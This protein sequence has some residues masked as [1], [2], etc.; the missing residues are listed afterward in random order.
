MVAVAKTK[1][2][3]VGK[4]ET[5]ASFK[6]A[7]RNADQLQQKFTGVRIAALGMGAAIG[8]ATIAVAALTKRA[9]DNADEIGKTAD[10]IGVATAELQE[11]R[12]GAELA[13]VAV[14]AADLGLQRFSRR[15]G[16]AAQGVGE[17]KGILAEYNIEVRDSEGR[18]RALIDILGDYAE[19]VQN[20]ESD[21]ERLRLAFKAFDSEGAALVNLLRD[22]REGIEGFREEAQRLGIVLEDELIDEAERARDA[23]TRIERVVSVNLQRVFLQL[24]PVIEDFADAFGRAAPQILEAAEALFQFVFGA[25]ATSIEELRQ[26]L[27]ETN[28]EILRMQVALAQSQAGGVSEQVIEGQRKQIVALKEEAQNLRDLIE[29]RK[30]DQEERIRLFNE[31]NQAVADLS[32]EFNEKE[33]ARAVRLQETIRGEFL[34][35]FEREQEIVTLRREKRL[36][37]IENE[38]LTEEERIIARL[39]T[40]AVFQAQMADI[41]REARFQELEEAEQYHAEQTRLA[42]RA[43]AKQQQ[44]ENLKNQAILSS[45]TSFLKTGQQIVGRESK[46][47]FQVQKALAIVEALIHTYSAAWK[48]FDF[49]GATGPGAYAAAAAAIAAGLAN[50]ALIASQKYDGGGGSSGSRG[51]GSPGGF[52]G[53]SGAAFATDIPDNTPEERPPQRVDV[54]L[55]PGQELFSKE[56]VEAIFEGINDLEGESRRIVVTP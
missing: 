30:E 12:F 46:K 43:A 32:Q 22:G 41:R 42:Q 5:A 10:K 17:L 16:E 6:S 34:K 26:E 2:R 23:L 20:A 8:A 50:V 25:E 28:D 3:I 53:S 56:Q 14:N 18:Q 39:E 11:F 15:V 48:Q 45:T 37:E 49:Y 1:L 19:A 29:V 31:G 47:A 54:I 13:G 21:Q 35:T 51:G 27:K 52:S 55:P 38:A 44:V 33:R 24:A 40:E 7:A 36:E 9:I 4:D